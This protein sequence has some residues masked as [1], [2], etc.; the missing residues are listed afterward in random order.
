MTAADAL[1]LSE[2]ACTRYRPME[3]VRS[4]RVRLLPIGLVMSPGERSP[5]PHQGSRR[6]AFAGGVL[7]AA[8]GLV[9][10]LALVNTN[11]VAVIEVAEQARLQQAAESALS[12]AAAT[13]N[14]FG[15]ALL[16]VGTDQDP[17]LALAAIDEV[18]ITLEALL[19]RA[20][21]IDA[22]T[23]IATE[24]SIGEAAAATEAA[25]A[26]LE[27]GD[28][29]TAS[30]MAFEEVAATFDTIVAE[31]VGVR[32]QA[33][34]TIAAAAGHSSA[35]STATRFMVGLLVPMFASVVLLVTIR[36]R[37]RRL[38]LEAELTAERAINQS[39]DQLIANIS[40]ELRTPLTGIYTTALTMD[41]FGF[42]DRELSRELTGVIIDQSADLT[43][44]VEDLLVSAQVDAGRLSFSLKPLP[45]AEQ[46]RATVDEFAR[47]APNIT[48]TTESALVMLDPGRFRQ[49]MRNLVS[50]AIRYG[51]DHVA[52][53]GRIAG[54][55]YVVEVADNG[56]GLPPDMEQRLFE[57][58][59]HRGD[60]PLIVGSVGLGLAITKVLANE[61]GGDVAYARDEA[62]TR[63]VVTLPLSL[64]LP[65]SAATESPGGRTTPDTTPRIEDLMPPD[66]SP[67]EPPALFDDDHNPVEAAL[68]TIGLTGHVASALSR[69]DIRTTG[70]LAALTRPALLD[71]RGIGPARLAA[72]EH[73]LASAGL[74]LAE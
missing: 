28:L 73:A 13:R 32:D 66:P 49:I 39:K 12:A 71:V 40:H 58:F 35:S 4:R 51:N 24:S 14:A 36:R 25:L 68:S 11:A 74:A 46:I 33:A 54:A 17:A 64:R 8:A 37:R 5:G 60:T 20:A 59:V 31:F 15:Q 3:Q 50:N 52:V 57:R 65:R 41:E 69:A 7:V 16:I 9:A 62:L 30:E 23:D 44:M 18:R 2:A 43:R 70:Q 21:T 42:D 27:S 47:T 1:E 48:V 22:L 45:I 34:S 56:P 6:R 72:V 10:S 29:D 26:V 19:D 53:T 67:I 61:M 38:L 63:F 55:T